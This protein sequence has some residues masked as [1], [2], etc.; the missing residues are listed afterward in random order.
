MEKTQ[1]ETALLEVDQDATEVLGTIRSDNLGAKYRYVKNVDTTA[2]V[3]KQPVCLDNAANAGTL[4]LLGDATRPV[5][6]ELENLM[7]VP[8]TAIAASGATNCCHGWVQVLGLA[9]NC[10]VVTPATG[11]SAITVGDS[12]IAVNAASYLTRSLIVGTAPIYVN[13]AI[14]QEAVAT[15]TGAAIALIDVTLSCL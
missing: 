9:Q 7:G 13:T 5:T 10:R 4:A 8:M 11:A 2:F 3:Q 6:A 14:A 15:A 1:F 12:L